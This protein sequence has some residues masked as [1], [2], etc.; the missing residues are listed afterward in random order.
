MAE[1]ACI[2]E[3]EILEFCRKSL[4]EYKIPREILFV[5]ELPVGGNGKV[6]RLKLKDV[7][8]ARRVK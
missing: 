8:N 3:K 1:G 4:V 7:Y 2:G 6:Q 5:D